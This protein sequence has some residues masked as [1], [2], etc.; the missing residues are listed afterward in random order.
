M[1]I[2]VLFGQ[3]KDGKGDPVV[4]EAVSGDEMNSPWFRKV[5]SK[6]T[7]DSDYLGFAV[8]DIEVDAE[9]IRGLCAVPTM[10]GEIA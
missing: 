8:V 6:W 2:R 4:L 5:V 7:P 10:K 9:K 3:P 1:K